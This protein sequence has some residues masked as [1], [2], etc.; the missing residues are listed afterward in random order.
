MS[1]ERQVN[2]R[3][4]AL[5]LRV[6]AVLVILALIAVLLSWYRHYRQ[7]TEE[8]TF[9]V[10]STTFASQVTRLHEVWLIRGEPSSIYRTAGDIYFSSSGWPTHV[11][12]TQEISPQKGCRELWEQ[13]LGQPSKIG[14]AEVGVVSA[15]GGCQFILRGGLSISYRF[16]NGQVSFHRPVEMES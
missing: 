13:L 6:V 7:Q 3:M 5:L 9:R 16:D 11:S 2:E 4:L 14:D 10:L 1:S 15:G 12:R 8:V